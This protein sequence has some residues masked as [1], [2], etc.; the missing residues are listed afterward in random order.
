[1]ATRRKKRLPPADIVFVDHGSIA[2][3]CPQTAKG[4]TWARRNIGG[5]K[6]GACYPSERRYAMDIA[7]GAHASGLI[8]EAKRG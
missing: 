6:Q 8:L 2:S 4:K 3:I 7:E 5:E 1:M